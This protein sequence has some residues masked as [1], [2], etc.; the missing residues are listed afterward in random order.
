MVNQNVDITQISYLMRAYADWRIQQI[1][2]VKITN[3]EIWDKK[4]LIKDL[5]AIRLNNV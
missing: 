5:K 4:R 3:G 2:L 1:N